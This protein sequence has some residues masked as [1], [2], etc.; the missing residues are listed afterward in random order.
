MPRITEVDQ[1]RR[2]RRCS[3][4][5]GLLLSNPVTYAAEAF[6][7]V[8]ALDGLRALAVCVVLL[9]HSDLG[10]LTGGF[11]GVSVFFT[12]SGFL[13]TSLLLHEH[14]SNGAISLSG[15][16]ARRLRRLVPAAYACI[17]LV[18]VLGVNWG[19]AQRRN[20]PVDVVASVLNIANWR[21]AAA[22]ASYQDLFA[23]AP[24]PLAHFWSLAIEEQCYLVLPLLAWWALRSGQRRFAGVLWLLLAM[25]IAAVLLTSDHDTIY[26]GTHTR[27]AELLLGALLAVTL[28][29][30]SVGNR[31]REVAGWTGLAVLGVA[32]VRTRIGDNWLYEGGLALVAVPSAALILGLTGTTTLAKA[33]AWSPLVAIGKVSFGLYLFHW[34][35]FLVLTPQRIDIDG[36]G[37]LLV[38]LAVTAALT[39]L[40]YR[41]LEQ[42]IRS[43]RVLSSPRLARTSMTAAAL[44]LLVVGLIAVPAPRLTATEQLLESATQPVIEIQPS[45]SASDAASESSTVEAQSPALLLVLGTDSSPLPAL[46]IAGW[47]VVDALHP[48]CPTVIAALATVTDDGPH[49]D[50][51]AN[52]TR[53]TRLAAEVEP[54]LVIVSL[55][56][57][58]A[59]ASNLNGEPLSAPQLLE[60]SQL[61]TAVELDIGR[62]L[63]ALSDL[64]VRMM[65]FDG[66][67][68][69]ESFEPLLDRVVVS[70]GLGTVHRSVGSLVTA[71]EGQLTALGEESALEPLRIMVIGDSTSFPVAQVLSNASNGHWQVTWAGA[72][73]CPFVRADAT[74]PTARDSW[75][76]VTCEPFDTKLPPLWKTNRPDLVLLVVGPMELLEQRYPGDSAG[77]VAGDPE[78]IAFHDSEMAE[79]VALVRAAGIQLI[80][81]DSPPITAGMWSSNEM[82]SPERLAAWN[83]QVARWAAIWPEVSVLPYADF[84][85][86]YEAKHGTIRPDGVHPDVTLSAELTRGAIIPWLLANSIALGQGAGNSEI[87]KHDSSMRATKS[88]SVFHWWA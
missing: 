33:L 56:P 49:V 79:L 6:G 70:L 4:L 50:C 86:A 18:V 80:I 75:K 58:D 83:A 1:S 57:D 88:S 39:V 72:N 43:G 46:R 63:E 66:A 45:A 34:P 67:P 28:H 5:N 7:Y 36:I 84:V 65:F 40:S 73:G 2:T 19:A 16:F 9:F 51:E 27:A 55:G 17:L 30:R 68:V 85:V 81:T 11:L 12:L 8:P 29:R 3:E 20:L 35:V 31:L 62:S 37:L 41:M 60:L 23:G 38:R 14:S 82:A 24:S 53:W 32:V 54:D 78:F 10:V 87:S 15:F 71:A 77:R 48:E 74:R 52:S 13:I 59:P 69:S 26:Y 25:S 22:S 47:E 64:G 61:M 76:E 21:F 44:G 42:P